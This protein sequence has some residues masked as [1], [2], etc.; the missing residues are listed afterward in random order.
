MIRF[1]AQ[2]GEFIPIAEEAG[3]NYIGAVSD[4]MAAVMQTAGLY[5]Q[6]DI[7]ANYGPFMQSFGT[8]VYTVAL[9]MGIVSIAVYGNYR[10]GVWL[11]V[12]P[13]MFYWLV[14]S[15]VPA[16]AAL[17]RFGS[18][19]NTD[20]A[21]ESQIYLDMVN[22]IAQDSPTPRVS[23]LFAK[24]DGVITE[25]VQNVVTL[26]VDTEFNE[27]LTIAATERIYSRV[28]ESKASDP[29][30]TTL[31]SVGVMGRCGRLNRIKMEVAG[32][33]GAS[34][35]TE[36]K[37]QAMTA[38]Y[39]VLKDQLQPIPF[40]GFNYI[41]SL[42]NEADTHAGTCA[43]EAP[44]ALEQVRTVISQ[45]QAKNGSL[46]CGQIW[47]LV[48]VGAMTEAERTLTREIEN[49]EENAI[50]TGS[51]EGLDWAEIDLRVRAAITKGA[52]PAHVT[53]LLAAHLLKQSLKYT[54]HSAMT[55]QIAERMPFA[56]DPYNFIFGAEPGEF[57]DLSTVEAGG[58]RATIVHFA[59][60][61]PYVQGLLLYLL[62][63]T[64]PFFAIFLLVPERWGALVVWMSMWTWVKCWDIGFATIYFIRGF[65]F[66]FMQNGMGSTIHEIDWSSQES[67]YRVMA[68]NDPMATNHLYY[69]LIAL[70]TLSVPVITAHFCAGAPQLYR[71]FSPAIDNPSKQMGQRRE[72]ERRL[73]L[74]QAIEQGDPRQGNPLENMH[75]LKAV[76]SALKNMGSDKRMQYLS[77][78][79]DGSMPREL[80]QIYEKGRLDW[81]FGQGKLQNQRIRM[82][83]AMSSGRN[84]PYL[85][86]SPG[87]ANNARLLQVSN[88]ISGRPLGTP[89]DTTPQDSSTTARAQGGAN[90]SGAQE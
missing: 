17:Q 31:V 4:L 19:V 65:I 34:G 37:R 41:E 27:D 66:E 28:V 14:Y 75:A 48:C 23:W 38:Q 2:G 51:D 21:I 64:F 74:T 78:M 3:G 12:G 70:L 30:F 68:E 9:I 42:G 82:Y 18:R 55:S 81:R 36:A 25:I 80:A 5:A 88:E 62:T 20:A 57:G 49:A 73:F 6:S 76:T 89:T 44:G 72:Q 77:K 60:W 46:S 53:Q 43:G 67:V 47:G 35:R 8:L 11:L 85:N 56:K 15:T 39:E 54:V 10:Q 7:L 69:N 86:N 40:N 71:V 13:S 83:N 61:V 45:G 59:G 33:A 26:L 52:D 29:G 1:F 58:A 50:E 79:A 84:E 90:I 87:I 22:V 63:I 32:T 16:P 24:F